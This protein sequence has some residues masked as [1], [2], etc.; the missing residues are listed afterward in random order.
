MYP[1]TNTSGPSVFP[2]E[3]GSTVSSAAVSTST[4]INAPS[5]PTASNNG[6]NNQGS[7]VTG[8]PPLIVAFLAV[9]V[10]LAA[11]LT[12]F[13]WRRV[14]F[15]RGLA[16]QPLGRDGFNT[17]RNTEHL[18]ERPELWDFWTQ[19]ITGS[20]EQLKWERI[21]VSLVQSFIHR[22][23]PL[24]RMANSHFQRALNG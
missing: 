13:G 21:M 20:R 16:M 23:G 17:P 19:P 3:Q 2:R 7:G 1:N 4:T 6:G 12:I 18:G 22:V 15:A 11:M 14:V 9:G 5:P 8:S 24:S 10:F